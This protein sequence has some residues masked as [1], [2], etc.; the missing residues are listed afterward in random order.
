MAE[1]FNYN[2][3][4]SNKMDLQANT[5]ETDCTRQYSKYLTR[6]GLF[7]PCSSNSANEDRKAQNN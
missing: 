1:D 7:N 3:L 2:I 6:M 4:Y 5:W